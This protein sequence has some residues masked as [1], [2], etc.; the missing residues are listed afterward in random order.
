MVCDCF[1]VLSSL[2]RWF[3]EYSM[4]SVRVAIDLRWC[5]FKTFMVQYNDSTEVKY[6][7]VFPEVFTSLYPQ[8]MRPIFLQ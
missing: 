1:L 7:F 5:F 8:Q 4:S 2:Q 3:S 6:Y